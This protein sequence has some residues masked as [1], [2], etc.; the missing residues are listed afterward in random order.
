MP[1]EHVGQ[2]ANFC[3]NKGYVARHDL[4][5]FLGIAIF[6][7]C[8]VFHADDRYIQGIQKKGDLV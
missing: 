1:G 5:R 3:G 2:A 6:S 8:V 7:E 4:P